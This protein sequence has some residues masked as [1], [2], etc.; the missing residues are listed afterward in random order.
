M[1]DRKTQIIKIA[2]KFI[3][4]AGFDSFSYKNLSEAVGITKATLHH[5]FAKKEDLGIAVCNHILD[6]LKLLKSATADKENAEEK[7]KFVF[8]C[9]MKSLD[10]GEICPIS[11]LQAEYN[12]IADSMKELIAELSN[13]EIT[14]IEEILREGLSDGSFKFEGEVK[15]MAVLILTSYKSSLLYARATGSPLVESNL[16]QVFKLMNS[17]Y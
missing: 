16:E 7:L 10:E 12:V 14:L 8:Q 13:F 4:E 1:E 5:H 6:N 11:S 9:L 2:M 3:E 15:A 17:Q